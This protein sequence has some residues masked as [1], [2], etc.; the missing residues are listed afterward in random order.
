MQNC[1]V[2]KLNAILG[3]QTMINFVKNVN[4][5]IYEL[6]IKEQ[7]DDIYPILAFLDKYAIIKGTAL[8]VLCYNNPSQRGIGDIDVLLPRDSAKKFEELLYSNKY[9]AL[10]SRQ[11]RIFALSYSH[12]LTPLLNCFFLLSIPSFEK[13]YISAVY[14]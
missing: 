12:Q 4:Q 3:E 6:I 11:Q 9:N 5:K 7:F 14:L 10:R 2:N 13:R 1:L 8:S